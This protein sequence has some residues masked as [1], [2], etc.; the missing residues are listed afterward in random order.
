MSSTPLAIAESTVP[1]IH[2]A[3]LRMFSP[4]SHRTSQHWSTSTRQGHHQPFMLG[5]MI[6]KCIHR[7]SLHSEVSSLMD[8][9]ASDFPLG[10]PCRRN[11]EQLLVVSSFLYPG[12]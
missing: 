1:C 12:T 10:E 7:H 4:K 3:T 5:S 11:M 8:Q 6:A 9:T 2:I